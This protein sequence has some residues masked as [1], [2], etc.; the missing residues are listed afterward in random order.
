MWIICLADDAHNRK[1]T[2][3]KNKLMYQ[4]LVWIHFQGE[5][6]VSQALPPS[7]KGFTLKGKNLLPMEEMSSLL[8]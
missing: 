4:A 1:K 5:V 2:T 8:E 6:F 3:F 7:E